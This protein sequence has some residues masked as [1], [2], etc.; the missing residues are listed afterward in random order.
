MCLQCALTTKSLKSYYMQKKTLRKFNFPETKLIEHA[1]KVISCFPTH[2]D[3]FAQ[4]DGLITAN[5]CDEIKVLLENYFMIV[6]S[7]VTIAELAILTQRV[8]DCVAN[9]VDVFQTIKFFAQKAFSGNFEILKRFGLSELVKSRRSQVR[10][11]QFMLNL[12]MVVNEYRTDLIGAGCKEEVIDSVKDIT[13]LLITENTQQELYKSRKVLSNKKRNEILNNIF[14]KLRLLSKLS[15]F[16]FA[17][18]PTAMKMYKMP[19]PKVKEK[20][21]KP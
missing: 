8:N 2:V 6:S 12:S 19:K 7:R 10:M 1:E 14:D 5:Y 15:K 21:L 17:D 16:V 18:N 3:K 11:I 9:A 20:K 13:N 4:F